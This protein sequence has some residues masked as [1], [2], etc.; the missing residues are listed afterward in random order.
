MPRRTSVPIGI[1]LAWTLFVW[2]GRIRN[3]VADVALEGAERTATLALSASFVVP[4]LVLAAGWA[5]RRSRAG[6]AL[7][8]GT[9]V[10]AGWTVA[11]WVVRAADI[12]LTSDEGVAFVLVHVVLALISVVLAGAASAAVRSRVEEPSFEHKLHR[13]AS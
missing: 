8:W 11:V 7:R 3:A 12:A 4:A 10:L 1:F 5:M 2:G 9:A 13:S 6:A